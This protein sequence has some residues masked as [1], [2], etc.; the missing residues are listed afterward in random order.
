MQW[1]TAN[2]G[3]TGAGGFAEAWTAWLEPLAEDLRRTEP[4]SS[5]REHA[6]AR[7]IEQMRGTMFGIDAAGNMPGS[8]A[9]GA[10]QWLRGVAPVL[11]CWPQLS[12]P[13]QALERALTRLAD[14]TT[15]ASGEL[16]Q[17]MDRAGGRWRERALAMPAAFIDAWWLA[18]QWSLAME[19]AW[20]ERLETATHGAALRELQ[21]TREEFR[22]AAA[23]LLDTAATALGLP[24][25]TAVAELE[26]AVDRL[27]RARDR[28]ADALRAEIAE[29]REEVRRLR[30][31]G[32]HSD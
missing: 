30:R 1:D 20:D 6:I 17:V 11:S 16:E 2:P 29:L 13:L 23:S 18:E 19:E 3:A 12:A 27:D 24:G 28:D 25:P 32:N 5:E 10:E 22:Q 7:V 26:A 14:A 4:G 8:G 21:R 31:D 9:G 15:A